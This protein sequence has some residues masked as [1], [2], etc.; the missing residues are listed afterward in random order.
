MNMRQPVFLRAILAAAWVFMSCATSGWA[1]GKGVVGGQVKDSLNDIYL[2]GVLV[3]VDNG[4]A[5]TVSDRDGGYSLSL[6]EGKHTISFSYL[7]YEPV[8]KNIT[9]SAGAPTALNIDFGETAVQMAEVVVTGQAVGQARALNQQKTAPNLKNVVASDAIGRFPDQNA[10]EALDRIPGVSIERDQ[11]EGRFVIVRGIDPHLN[12]ASVDGIALASAE[13]GTRAVLLDVLPMNVMGSLVVTKALTADMPA[14]SIGGHVDIITPSAYDRSERTLQGAIGGNYSDLTDEL[15]PSGQLTF[16]DVL[17][18]ND[19][20]GFLTSISYDKRKFGSDNVEADPWELNDDGQWVTEEL[21][22]REYDLTRERLGITTNLEFKPSEHHN[23]F[24]RGLYG[25]YTDHEYRNRTIIGDMMM[26]PDSSSTGVIMGEDYEDDEEA[27]YP[28]TEIQLKDREETQMNWMISTGGE[29]KLNTCT[30]DY[31]LA[32][33]YAEQDTPYDKQ[34]M[35]ETGDLNYSYTGA[36]SDTPGVAV[37]GGDINDL[38]IYE[39]DSVEESKQLVEEEACIFAANIKKE[40]NTSFQSYV[41]TGFHV[42]LRNKTNDLETIVYEDP[43]DDFSTLEGHTQDGRNEYNDFPLV[44]TD[45]GDEFEDVKD[46]FTSERDIEASEVEDYETDENVYAAYVMGEADFGKFTLLPGVRVEF[47]D[48]EARGNTYDEET[49]EV[50]SQ[51][52]SNDYTNVLP[53]LHARYNLSDN[54]ILYGAWTNTISRPQWEETRYGKFTD[55]DGNVEIGNPELD[56]Y[57]AMNWDAT[58]SYYMPN[59]LGLASIGF[60]YKDIDNFIYAQTSEMDDYELTTYR[61][62]DSG[63][64]YGVEL[65]YQ[66]KLGFLPSPLDGFSLEGNLTLSN[67]EADILATE[68]SEKGRTVDFIRHSDTVGVIALS[69]EK[70][71]V[72]LRLSGSYRSSYLDEVGDKLNEDRYIDD[73]FQLDFS[74]SYTFLDK[75]TLYLNVIN[76]TNEPLKAYFGESGRLSQYEEYGLAVR[77]GLK[78]NI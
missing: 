39:L 57:E 66:Q 17:G 74:S 61:N 30:L 19:Q 20:F 18:K 29:H 9:I 75:Y 47:T 34:F 6:T 69:Y 7:G 33:S 10:A 46:Q 32:Y 24:L 49:E 41:K 16:G 15:A 67:S 68:Q 1:A 11:G 44:N 22:Y 77:F 13:A 71:N 37:T 21:E 55:D 50:G 43:T 63:H 8:N 36:D 25:S 42:S 4:Q 59:S 28:T 54:L 26:M 27:L 70:Y 64:I 2:M 62:G 72:F 51:K 52:K 60:F 78:F 76:L 3:S 35:Y 48:L 45:L 23:F 40:L 53:S 31:K 58:L 65:V 14:D 73:H 56:P 5:K 38:S 12:A